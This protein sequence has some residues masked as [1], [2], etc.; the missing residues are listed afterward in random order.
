M[1]EHIDGLIAAPFVPLHENGDLSL[2]TV[3]EY[4]NLL[5]RDGV[6]GAFVNGT[7][8]EHASLTIPERLQVAE[9]W[10]A[11]APDDFKVIVHVGH[12]CQADCRLMA[13]HARE[14]G[15]WGIGAMAPYF[16]LPASVGD[17]VEWCAGIAVAAPNLPFYYYH[18][19]S[20]SRAQ[21]PM[22]DFLT[23]AARRIPNLAGIKFTFEDLD[24]YQRC[25]EFENRRFD[26][27][28]GRDEILLDGLERGS[29][30][31]V[32]STYNFAAPLYLRIIDRFREGD[33]K[34]ARCFQK[35]AHEMISRLVATGWGIGGFKAAMSIAGFN[36]G[37]ARP[38]L[39]N[40]DEEGRRKIREAISCL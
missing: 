28:F 16:F 25:V 12:T 9:R 36:C 21:F 4:I 1:I 26:I 39:R 19:P 22:I 3:P 31:A 8:G 14:I 7:T 30:G 35:T 29:R 23:Q 38:P 15:A 2:E 10:A 13:S 33:L 5:R 34:A 11:S 6:C 27:L 17:L 40:P 18:I 20:L 24:D 37:P 32:G